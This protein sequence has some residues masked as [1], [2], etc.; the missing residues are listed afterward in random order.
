MAEFFGVNHNCMDL[1]DVR[2]RLLRKYKKIFGDL[3]NLPD[4][5]VAAKMAVALIYGQPT[6]P[7]MAKDLL[8]RLNY[9]HHRSADAL[10][11]FTIGYLERGAE[12]DPMP[13]FD[14]SA[15]VRAVEELERETDWRYSGETDLIFLAS[16]LKITRD[17]HGDIMPEIALEFDHVVC[18]CL[19]KAIAQKT[20]SSGAGLIEDIVR[21]SANGNKL[22]FVME[23]SGVLAARHAKTGFV[24]WLAGLVKI[25]ADALRNYSSSMTAD[26]RGKL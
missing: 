2:R 14:D 22:H 23:L 11:I 21:A 18:L 12:D 3:S 9:I 26:L 6:A 16:S 15:F 1:D 7:A 20:V 13:L 8:P 19:E 5:P 4:G 17:E 25:D 24:K 10:E